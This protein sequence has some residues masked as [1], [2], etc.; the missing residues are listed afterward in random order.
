[1]IEI[2]YFTRH[3]RCSCDT[4]DFR[5]RELLLERAVVESAIW[6]ELDPIDDDPIFFADDLP[7]HDI[8][9]MLDL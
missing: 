4:E 8:R 2:Q 1:M 6:M 3:I 7:R 9:M 5:M